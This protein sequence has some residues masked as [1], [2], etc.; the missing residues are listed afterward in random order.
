MGGGLPFRAGVFDGA[1]S[2]SAIQ[3]LC[4]SNSKKEDPRKRLL[5]FFESLFACLSRS[6]RA[7]FQFYPENQ[8]QCDLISQQALKAGFQVIFYSFQY[9][10]IF[11]KGWP[12]Y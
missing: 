1:I 7:I 9:V 11:S 3:W 2:V 12:C 5:K 4:H 8:K 10:I 6:A